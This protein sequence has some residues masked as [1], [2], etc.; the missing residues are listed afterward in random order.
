M[1]V[2]LIKNG[3]IYNTNLPL[4]INGS[5]WIEDK[6]KNNFKRNLINIEAKDG[7]WVLK[8]NFETKVVINNQTIEEVILDDYSIYELQ[9]KGEKYNYI[10]CSS[11][12]YDDQSMEFN[13]DNNVQIYIGNGDSNTINYNNRYVAQKQAL[14][15]LSNGSWSLQNLTTNGVIF[16]NGVAVNNCNLTVGDIVFIMNLKIIICGSYIIV[17]KPKGI[18]NYNVDILKK[19]VPLSINSKEKTIEPEEDTEIKVY[20][21]SE[22]FFRMPRFRTSV[23]EEEVSIDPPPEQEKQDEMP[24]AYTLGPMITMGITS[25][26][27]GV[28]SLSNVMSG[29]QSVSSALPSLITCIAML[30]SM[31]LWPMLQKRFET[32]Q[33]KKREKIRIKK[34]NEYI[35]ERR[36]YIRNIV[37]KQRQSLMENNIPLEECK[38]I[39]VNRKRNLW[40]RKIEH[41]DFLNLRIGIGNVEPYVKVNY[42]EEHFS[43]TENNLREVLDKLGSE[44]KIMTDVPVT[45]NLTNKYISAIIGKKQVTKVFI[46]GVLLQLMAF[47]SYEDLKIIVMTSKE[48]EDRWKFLKTAPYCTDDDK[49]IRFF[50]TDVDEANQISI[51]LD[52]YFQNR[53]YQLV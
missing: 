38:Q 14:L 27:S 45:V 7:K 15:T 48:N 53:K 29:T 37:S 24:L 40:E 5:F 34:Y 19:R 51:Y 47:H 39:I 6:D 31:M 42:P 41:D 22:Y 28:T 32:K 8:S 11:P 23:E 43:L 36:Q 9:V 13:V 1:R 20:D 25:M 50:S 26:V 44:T 33:R 49:T 17:N 35:E 10:L 3:K 2:S 12:V 46:E 18:I 21:K 30:C 52:N 4:K 16:V